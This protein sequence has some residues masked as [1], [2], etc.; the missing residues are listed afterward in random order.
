[1]LVLTMQ[2]VFVFVIMIVRVVVMRVLVIGVMVVMDVA[3]FVRLKRGMG[4]RPAQCA[5]IQPVADPD[6]QQIGPGKLLGAKPIAHP[7]DF[8]G[9]PLKAG[10]RG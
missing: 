2:L 9:R 10:Q 6:A 8:H 3:R 1:M 7:F 5:R 4:A